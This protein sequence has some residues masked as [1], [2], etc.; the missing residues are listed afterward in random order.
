MEKIITITLLNGDTRLISVKRRRKN[1][2]IDTKF[3]EKLR[4]YL[5]YQ[6]TGKT[7]IDIRNQ[8]KQ[9]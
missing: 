1:V 9:R 2:S 7:Q 3:F 8:P 6:P 4:I 5:Y